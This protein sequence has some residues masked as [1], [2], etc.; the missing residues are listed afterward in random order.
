MTI[1]GTSEASSLKIPYLDRSHGLRRPSHGTQDS[2][3]PTLRM[4]IV[5]T[6]DNRSRALINPSGNLG[7]LVKDNFLRTKSL[8]S[9]FVFAKEVSPQPPAA[10]CRNEANIAQ[11][12]RER[13]PHAR[14]AP[15]VRKLI[16]SAPPFRRRVGCRVPV[17]VAVANFPCSCNRPC[18]RGAKALRPGSVGA[19]TTSGYEKQLGMN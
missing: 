14:M 15:V 7:A 4:R 12:I 17:R 16:D 10:F 9:A 6:S 8:D 11:Q 18:D 5:S 13:T 1:E 2:P 19:I 3:C